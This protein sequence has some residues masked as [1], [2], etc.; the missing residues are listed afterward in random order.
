MM[1]RHQDSKPEPVSDQYERDDVQLITGVQDAAVINAILAQHTLFPYHFT[2]NADSLNELGQ[3]DLA[4]MAEYFRAHPGDLNVRRGD[5]SPSLYDAR[6]KFVTAALA[7]AGVDTGRIQI[8]DDPAGGAGMLSDSV[9]T[10]LKTK[11]PSYGSQDKTLDT[12]SDSSAQPQ[13]QP[14]APGGQQ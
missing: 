12:S 11:S 5:E 3:R 4:V 9:V 8:S 1:K 2:L 13:Q 7:H 14:S 10:I 6:V